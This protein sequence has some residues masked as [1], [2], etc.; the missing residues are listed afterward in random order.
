MRLSGKIPVCKEILNTCNRGLCQTPKHFF[1]NMETYVI[2]TS[3]FSYFQREK[4]IFKFI[5]RCYLFWLGS[6]VFLNVLIKT[7]SWCTNYFAKI[8]PI[9]AKYLLKFSAVDF[10]SVMLFLSTRIFLE[11]FCCFH[12]SFPTAS[13]RWIS[14][15]VK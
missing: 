6:A 8:G 15:Y 14:Q 5:Y 4:I 9:W 3:T 13:L 1:C 11:R 12:F 7:S 10:V 2:I